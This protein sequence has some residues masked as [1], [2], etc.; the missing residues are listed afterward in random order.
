MTSNKCNHLL[1]TRLRSQVFTD[2]IPFGALPP[3]QCFTCPRKHAEDKYYNLGKDEPF[4]PT[5]P[6]LRSGIRPP[7]AQRKL[8]GFLAEP[9]RRKGGA[10]VLLSL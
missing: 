8:E 6:C 3:Q 2:V 4:S 10:I 9:Q 1:T 7:R 5:A